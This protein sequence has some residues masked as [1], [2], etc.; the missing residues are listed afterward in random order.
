MRYILYKTNTT[1]NELVDMIIDWEDEMNSNLPNWIGEN[2]EIL[3]SK[4][5]V[6]GVVY[7]GIICELKDLKNSEICSFS[8][9]KRIAEMFAIANND[10]EGNIHF[11]HQH[12]HS[13][14]IE[15]YGTYIDLLDLVK[16]INGYSKYSD[17]H[18]NDLT[19]SKLNE[20]FKKEELEVF[21]KLDF[22]NSR[23]VEVSEYEYKP[24]LMVN[25][26]SHEEIIYHISNLNKNDLYKINNNKIKI[27]NELEYN[28][29]CIW[30]KHK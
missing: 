29:E 21:M 14:L 16:D 17:E 20:V 4:Y 18:L 28:T 19:I 6:T 22:T 25:N 3:I 23:V 10:H 9:S 15:S 7:R 2:I 11:E 1:L 30:T 8:K 13:F 5:G 26:H 27:Q 24:R 12:K